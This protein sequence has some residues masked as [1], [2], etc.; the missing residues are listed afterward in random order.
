MT[1]LSSYFL[2]FP[3]VPGQLDKL[4]DEDVEMEPK[5][6]EDH[7]M[8]FDESSVASDT[9]HT[10]SAYPNLCVYPVSELEVANHSAVFIPRDTQQPITARYLC[11]ITLCEYRVSKL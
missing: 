2:L 1:S 11:H 9:S 10:N 8:D 7:V 6:S 3:R 4:H 5:K